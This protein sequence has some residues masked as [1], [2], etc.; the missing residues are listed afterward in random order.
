M[1]VTPAQFEEFIVNAIDSSKILAHHAATRGWKND[2]E[3]H[4]SNAQVGTQCPTFL[5]CPT[6]RRASPCTRSIA[7][8][9]KL[10]LQ[11]I[12]DSSGWRGADSRASRQRA[13]GAF[14]IAPA[15]RRKIARMR[16]AEGARVNGQ[17]PC[18]R[19]W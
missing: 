16:V 14:R 8:A 18:K 9:Q 2:I 17:R 6:F 15:L 12:G 5:K 19:F 4:S 7:K 10:R 1:T 13:F 11:E 3:L